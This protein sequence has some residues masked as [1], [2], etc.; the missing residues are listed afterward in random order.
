MKRTLLALFIIGNL[1]LVQAQI[2]GY[3]VGQ[4]VAN[5]TVTDTD[6]NTHSLY[7][8]TAAGK[9]V[10]LD[11][12]FVT[13]PPC[14][15]TTPIFNQLHDKYGCNAGDLFC[16]SVNTGQDNDAAVDAFE[17][18]YGG[19]FNHSPAVSSDGGSAAV[20]GVFNPAAYPTYCLIGPDNKLIN[21][22]IWPISSVAD[23]EAAFP[24]ASGITA[25]ACAVGMTEP[26]P[27]AENLILAVYPNPATSVATINFTSTEQVSALVIELIDVT[28]RVVLTQNQGN[29][30]AGTNV[31]TIDVN[32]LLAGSYMI[33]VKNAEAILTT[34]RFIV[35]R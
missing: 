15:Q 26:E 3:T 10:M 17:A 4:T 31:F 6:G 30:N 29:V 23:F 7:S 2:Q 22:D 24:V 16:L 35:A 27:G 20:D 11:F 25:M 8:Y 12:F 1:G 5:F 18:T 33:R 13:C 21:A 32:A 9:Y 14:Q 34:T 19:T 28:G